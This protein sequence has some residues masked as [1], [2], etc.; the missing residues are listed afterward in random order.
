M[1]VGDGDVIADDDK[2]CGVSSYR[3]GM[4]AVWVCA[5]MYYYERAPIYDLWEAMQNE[6]IHFLNE[7]NG[8]APPPKPFGDAKE[9]PLLSR[10]FTTVKDNVLDLSGEYKNIELSNDASMYKHLMEQR[11]GAEYALG[12]LKAKLLAIAEGHSIVKLPCGVNYKV[13]KAGAVGKRI[14]VYVPANPDP[15]PPAP[16]GVGLI[17]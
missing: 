2:V 14:E 1:L 17:G 9:V 3:W 15:P 12:P 6:A 8:V 16:V 10:S 11:T 5:D 7:V 4:L 13:M